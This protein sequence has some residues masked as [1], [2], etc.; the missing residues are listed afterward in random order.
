MVGRMLCCSFKPLVWHREGEEPEWARPY[1]FRGDDKKYRNGK[2]LADD[3]RLAIA[4]RDELEKYDIIVGHN[5][6]LFDRK[7]LN[8]R[9]MRYGERPLKSMWHLDTMW[10]IRTH[11]AMSSKLDNVQKHMGLPDEKTPIT[12][13][14]WQRGAGF[15]RAA[16]D[17]IVQHC[18]QD[19]I[20]LAQ[21]YW[22]LLPFVRDIRRA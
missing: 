14:D 9:L 20:V 10:I 11:A 19:V 21:A 5:S 7:F 13:D 2:D 16:M 15:D 3:S 18:E 6:K 17:Q 12:W 4:V 1:T 8:A 22:R